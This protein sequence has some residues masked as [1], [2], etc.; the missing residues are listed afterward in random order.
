M[1]VPDAY[2]P[3]EEAVPSEFVHPYHQGTMSKYT[4]FM[5]Q[6]LDVWEAK[7]WPA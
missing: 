2:V 7:C 3:L 1:G 6:L 5:Q 4:Y